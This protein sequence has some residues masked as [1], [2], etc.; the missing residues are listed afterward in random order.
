[1]KRCSTILLVLAVMMS[2]APV[3][4]VRADT[5]SMVILPFAVSSE[6]GLTGLDT[7]L[8]DLFASR[9]AFTNKLDIVDT[10]RA[11]E[12]YRNASEAPQERIF[13]VGRETG[14]D[15][16]LTGSLDDSAKGIVLRAF[17]LDTATEKP[18]MELSEKSGPYDNADAVI[19][20]VNLIADRINRD[21]FSRKAPEAPEPQ[22]TDSPYNIYAHPDKLLEF[23]PKKGK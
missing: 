23:V 15:Y 21:L 9:I 11:V 19:V 8:I 17:V 4:A 2:A 18:L 10:V 3:A 22:P 6:S 7:G 5:P 16:V 12:L 1:M 14:A 13:V 20:L